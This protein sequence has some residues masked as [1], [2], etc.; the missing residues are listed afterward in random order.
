MASQTDRKGFKSPTATGKQFTPKIVQ[1]SAKKQSDRLN[2][3]IVTKPACTK[4]SYGDCWPSPAQPS[5]C[6]QAQHVKACTEAEQSASFASPQLLN[7][8]NCLESPQELENLNKEPAS[9]VRQSTPKVGAQKELEGIS[10]KPQ[11]HRLSLSALSHN[12]TPYK[13]GMLQGAGDAGFFQ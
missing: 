10:A 7:S 1:T 2:E 3:P 6:N 9:K 5:F 11:P 8:R 13:E 4:A 12:L